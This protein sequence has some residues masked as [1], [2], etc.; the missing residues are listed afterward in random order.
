MLLTMYVWRDLKTCCTSGCTTCL[1]NR[2]A[3]KTFWIST[4]C[5]A[6][7]LIW[8]GNGTGDAPMRFSI[9]ERIFSCSTIEYVPLSWFWIQYR[10]GIEA[11]LDADGQT[12]LGDKCCME[13]LSCLPFKLFFCL[14]FVLLCCNLWTQRAIWMGVDTA[15]TGNMH[16]VWVTTNNKIHIV[17]MTLTQTYSTHEH[18]TMTISWYNVQRRTYSI[19]TLKYVRNAG[20]MIQSNGHFSKKD[21]LS[22]VAGKFTT[23]RTIV[24]IVTTIRTYSFEIL[25]WY[26]FEIDAS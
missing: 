18:L 4:S 26:S 13:S 5:S 19:I 24:W 12:T 6:V 22:F 20:S 17:T 23:V 10:N 15:E 21:L 16:A 8:G 11:K 1:Y 7:W 2:C 14:T 25:L 9:T 3:E